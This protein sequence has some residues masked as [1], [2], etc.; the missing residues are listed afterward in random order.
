MLWSLIKVII[1]IGLAIA[2]SFGLSFVMETPGGVTLAFGAKEITFTPIGFVVVIVLALLG[3]WL[4]LKL[5][6]LLVA[7]LRFASG[8]ETALSRFWGRKRERKGYDAL[9]ESMIALAA[10]EGTTA[11]A[12]AAKAERLLK[13]PE[14][15]RLIS[16]QA[17]EMAGDHRKALVHYKELLQDDRTR[18]VGVQGILKQ[19]LAEGD[20]ETALKLAKK[21]FVLRPRHPGNLD[22]LFALQSETADWDGARQTLL[23]KQQAKVLP[24]DVVKRRDAVLRL[25]DALN[26]LKNDDTA[27][28]R[29]MALQANRLSPT[30]IPAA[31]LAARMQ[32]EAGNTRPA[33]RMLKTAWQEMPH[34]DIATAFGAL[35]PDETPEARRKRFA[36]LVRL[37]AGHPE[38]RMLLAEMALV[39]GDF[40][41][42]RRALGNLV[43]EQPTT[44]SLALMAAIEKG[45][46]AAESVI[47]AFLAKALNASRGEQWVCSGCGH[48]H[49]EWHPTCDNCK[50]FDTLEWKAPPVSDVETPMDAVLPMI[51]GAEPEPPAGDEAEI[52]EAEIPGDT[53][54]EAAT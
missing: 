27:K 20:T 5:A 18:F 3:F 17:S 30:L 47:R 14:L 38:T 43:E 8:D 45:T 37:H 15:T 44:R 54:G 29:E 10:G 1:F 48:A 24:K 13:R 12:K 46:G 53:T 7:V 33:T 22:T 51:I 40:P 19:K 28:A 50:A 31:V 2:L 32:A 41:E 34:P 6:G 26:A 49:G 35:A 42:A 39:E 21:A 4:L 36:P 11:E 52:L 9:A 25:A 16:A 23:A